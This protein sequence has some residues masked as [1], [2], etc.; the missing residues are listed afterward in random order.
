MNLDGIYIYPHVTM[1]FL[2]VERQSEKNTNI[3]VP[4]YIPSLN[5]NSVAKTS[6]LQYLIIKSFSFWFTNDLLKSISVSSISIP[7]FDSNSFKDPP[8]QSSLKSEKRYLF[9]KE[10]LSVST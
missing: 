3:Y 7:L 2:H 10:I 9:Q 4:Q 8:F 6:C 1:D 5:N